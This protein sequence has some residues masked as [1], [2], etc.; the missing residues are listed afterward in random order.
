MSERIVAPMKW[1]RCRRA[2]GLYLVLFFLAVVSAPHHHLNDLEDLLLDQ[3]SDSGIV[4]L[5]SGTAAHAAEEAFQ[6]CLVTQDVACLACFTRDFV[7]VPTSAFTLV[8]VFARLPLRPEPPA[9]A[10]PQLLPADT[11][12]RAPPLSS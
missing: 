2:A 1:S 9:I 6:S 8:A 10:T 7:S 3:R 11:S 12:S 5:P 4:V